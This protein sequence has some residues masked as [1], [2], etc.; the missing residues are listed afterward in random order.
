MGEIAEDVF[1]GTVCE[2][3]LCYF[4]GE[5][6]DTLHTHGYPVVCWDCW[7]DLTKK[8]RTQYQRALRATV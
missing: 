6:K 1:G 2:L 5:K 4:R 8:Q 7:Q 3:C